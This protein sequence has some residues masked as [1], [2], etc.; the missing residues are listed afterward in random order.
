MPWIF[1]SRLSGQAGERCQRLLERGEGFSVRRAQRRPICR[2]TEIYGGLL[3]HL[4]P[5]RVVGNPLDVFGRPVAR[6]PLERPGDA[7]MQ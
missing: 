6:E 7:G 5:Q 2:L 3:P 1:V 4:S